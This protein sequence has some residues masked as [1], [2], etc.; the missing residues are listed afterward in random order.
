M[1]AFVVGV[2]HR[3]NPVKKLFRCGLRHAFC[4][5]KFFK[6]SRGNLIDAL[7]GALSRQ[8]YRNQQFKW[9]LIVQLRFGFRHLPPKPIQYGRK[10]LLLCHRFGFKDINSCCNWQ[11]GF[12]LFFSCFIR[13]GCRAFSA[14]PQLPN[15][16]PS[17]FAGAPK[18]A[19][20]PSGPGFGT[21]AG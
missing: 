12:K 16:W 3:P 14:T 1:I 20:A 4:I 19:S 5:W 8:N 10:S 6:K 11:L 2:T 21:L 18:V 9:T 15:D 17:W 7:V 13:G